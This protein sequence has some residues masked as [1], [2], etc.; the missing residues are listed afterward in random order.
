MSH[1]F[2]RN[3]TNLTYIGRPY[4][5]VFKPGIY[6]FELF[7]AS[8]GGSQPGF[9]AYV[10]GITSIKERTKMHIYVGQKGFIGT[11]PSYNGGGSGTDLVNGV[12]GGTSGGGSTDIRLKGGVWNDFSSLKSR[13]MVAG[14][15]GGSQKSIY[16]T[17][18]GDAGILAGFDGESS[19]ST[20][21]S[22]KGGLQK[23]PGKKGTGEYKN[24]IDGGFGVGANAKPGP[25]G[26]GGGSG[27][28]G[29]GSGAVSNGVVGSGA[30]GSSFISGYEGC[31]AIQRSATKDNPVFYEH[32]Y[33]YSGYYFSNITALDGSMTRW[34]N[35]GL[36]RITQIVSLPES[37]KQTICKTRS[38]NF[39]ILSC[40]L[41]STK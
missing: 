38:L 40:I 19:G 27:Y 1:I 26:C 6:L 16:I 28:F 7:G 30:G 33:H 12:D 5:F 9:G 31:K 15:G 17:K 21:V 37:L 14:A 34:D 24:G 13:I 25:N 35:D 3:G 18:G 10:S 29:G 23:E 41:I 39:L 2:N 20:V 36:A 4:S 32:Q 22:S 11:T 8:G